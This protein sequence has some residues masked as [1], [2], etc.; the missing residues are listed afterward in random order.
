MDAARGEKKDDHKALHST[1]NKALEHV[2][3][4]RFAK[5]R[6]KLCN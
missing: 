6:S 1:T 2:D 4:R 3:K 5:W